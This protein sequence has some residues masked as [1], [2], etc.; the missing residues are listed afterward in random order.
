MIVDV[1]PAYIKGYVTNS[2]IVI[3]RDRMDEPP[4]SI[5]EDGTIIVTMNKYAVIPVEEYDRLIRIEVQLSQGKKI[6]KNP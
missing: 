5:L 6:Q 3:D 2:I 1:F 4:F